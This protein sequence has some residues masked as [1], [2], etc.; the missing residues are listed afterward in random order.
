MTGR[1]KGQRQTRGNLL[2]MRRGENPW[3]EGKD[4]KGGVDRTRTGKQRKKASLKLYSK[5]V[6]ETKEKKG[7]EGLLG[8]DRR[9]DGEAGRLLESDRYTRTQLFGLRK[10]LDQRGLSVMVVGGSEEASR[11]RRMMMDEWRRAQP[12]TRLVLVEGKWISGRRTN[13]R[14]IV[15]LAKKYRDMS[16]EAKEEAEGTWYDMH[17]KPREEWRCSTNVQRPGRVIF[18]EP[19]KCGTARSEARLCGVPTVGRRPYDRVKTKEVDYMATL[20]ANRERKRTYPVY[21]VK[22]WVFRYRVKGV[23]MSMKNQVKAKQLKAEQT[24]AVKQEKRQGEVMN[25]Q[26]ESSEMSK[27]VGKKVPGKG[28]R[29]K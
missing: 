28:I 4:L 20:R 26:M 7:E 17:V 6:E 21:N 19:H 25:G 9:M 18:R 8:K 23:M 10:R 1:R 12:N 29:M 27:K 2:R 15:K 11:S 3:M 5:R 22:P 13:F 16:E 14:Q 24:E